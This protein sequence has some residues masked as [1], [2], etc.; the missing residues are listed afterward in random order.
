MGGRMNQKFSEE[1][2][3]T[4]QTGSYLYH[5]YA[6]D[7]PIIDYHC[8]L[9]A[10]EIF[11]NKE[12][13]DL[14]EMW[15]AHDHYKWRAMRT[16]G[17]DEYYIT[18]QAGFFEKYLKFA[19]ILPLLIGNP[20]YIWCALELKRY[21]SIDEPLGPDNAREIYEET[22]KQIRKNHITPR[23]CME[24]SKVEVVS[25]TEDPIDTLEYHIK[26]KNDSSIK[27]KILTAFR[28]DKAFYCEKSAY[29]EYLRKLS[30]AAGQDINS[31]SSMIAALKSRLKFF[32]EFGTTV[33]DNGIASICWSDYTMEEVEVAF[34]KAAS[35]K[36]L[37]TKEINQ[38]KSAFL[39]EMAKCYKQ[40]GFVMQ[41]HIGTYLDANRKK[42]EEIG[43]STGFDCVDDSTQIQSV[44]AILNRLTELN[45]LPKTI[46]YPL[47]AAQVEPFSILA[48]GFCDGD[49]KAKVQ[50]GAPWWFNDQAFGIERQFYATG[51]LYPVC[52]SV[53]M[54]TDSRSFISYPRHELYRR[55]LCNYFGTL[56]ERGEYFS[57]ETYIKEIIEDICYK[58][59]KE[60]FGW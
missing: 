22:K 34:C 51:N 58:N 55:V 44:G 48:A 9:E 14:G 59:V 3:L 19:E 42:V 60:Y 10:K 23:W 4:N 20:I 32:A 13:E 21:F 43:P 36:P 16:F 17:I 53:G 26:M 24:R 41:L 47:N 18:G 5:T 8:H 52:L 30:A 57:D 12:F 38:Y 37:S 7:L 28:P 40:Y 15:L 39:I 33:S 45:E 35:G 49:E 50:L 54:L 46:L 25:T 27:T 56:I 2:F 6:E 29:V 31:F 1:L 11:E